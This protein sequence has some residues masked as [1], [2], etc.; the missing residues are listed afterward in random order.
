MEVDIHLRR[1]YKE[2]LPL[3]FGGNRGEYPLPEVPI[4]GTGSSCSDGW[5][6]SVL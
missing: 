5:S 3:V 6:C 4:P 2:E 1:V